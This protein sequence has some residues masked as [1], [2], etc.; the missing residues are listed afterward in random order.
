LMIRNAVDASESQ[1][2]G[3]KPYECSPSM[4][5]SGHTKGEGGRDGG[6]ERERDRR[7]I[8]R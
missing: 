7:E 5:G 1:L 4:S 3:F 8:G 2:G 6:R